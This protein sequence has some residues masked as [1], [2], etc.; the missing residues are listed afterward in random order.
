MKVEL[1]EVFWD[2]WKSFFELFFILFKL[3]LLS[4]FKGLFLNLADLFINFAFLFSSIFFCNA[5]E[6]RKYVNEKPKIEQYYQGSFDSEGKAHGKGIWIK[7]SNIYFGNFSNDKFNGKGLFINTKGNY[8]FGE[9][10]DNK[11]EGKGE[12]IIDS[13]ET[14]KGN[15]KEN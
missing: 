13:I 4:F 14:Y 2:K 7:N 8:Y 15:L 12:F 6:L 11:I 9:W 5:I 3:F 10:K 1:N